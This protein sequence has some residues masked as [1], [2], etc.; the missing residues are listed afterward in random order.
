MAIH[1]AAIATA[2]WIGQR[3]AGWRGVLGVAALLA[4]AIRGYGQ[5]LL[6]QPWNP[7]LPLL[8]WLVVLLATWSVLCGDLADADPAG[9]RRV[10]C[11]QTHVP[12]LVRACVDDRVARRRCGWRLAWSGD[13]AGGS[14]ATSASPPSGWCCGCRRSSTSDQRPGQRGHAA[15]PLR[16][17]ARAGA[18]RRRGDPAGPP[19]PR[20][21]GGVR[22]SSP[23][24]SR[25]RA[26]SPASR[27][28]GA[29]M[30]GVGVGGGRWRA[31]ARRLCG[32][33]RRRRR[34]GPRAGL[35]D[36]H[37]RLP[38]Y[39]LTL[40]AWGT[41]LVPVGAVVWTGDSWWRSTSA[42]DG[43]RPTAAHARRAV[44]RDDGGVGR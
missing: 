44:W 25:G 35:D 16:R 2:L 10:V 36:P 33:A 19:S 21:V 9:R 15:R 37:L 40:W 41:A 29:L 27:R 6:T 31:A 17:P 43:T 14:T 24:T 8:A 26:S 18:G 22:R 4:V 11:A 12:Y 30:L 32:A 3:R 39:Y 5:V 28:G 13:A 1:V 38:W 34:P 23:A 7:Y 20:R 42:R